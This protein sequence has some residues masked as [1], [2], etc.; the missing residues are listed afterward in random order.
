MCL[1]KGREGL[2]S[3]K[4]VGVGQRLYLGWVRGVLG[5]GDLEG[6]AEIQERGKE[7]SFEDLLLFWDPL[8][9]LV[10]SFFVN[11]LAGVWDSVNVTRNFGLLVKDLFPRVCTCE[12]L[13]QTADYKYPSF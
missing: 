7:R 6:P 9:G 12:P 2:S 1:V 4:E 11:A 3:E 10:N 8:L 13:L 5:L